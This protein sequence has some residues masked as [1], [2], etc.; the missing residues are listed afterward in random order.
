MENKPSTNEAM[1]QNEANLNKQFDLTV[2]KEENDDECDKSNHR[3]C[4]AIKRLLAALKYYDALNITNNKKNCNIFDDFINNVYD[5]QLLDDFT[6]LTNEHGEEL[7]EISSSII[8]NE[9]FSKCNFKTCQFTSRHQRLGN[10]ENNGNT[11]DAKLTFY[12]ETMDS[13][14]FYLFHCFDAG[15]RT[16][17]HD[18]DEIKGD[19]ENKNNLQYFD[20][21]F[22]RINKMISAR[23]DATDSFNRFKTQNTKF[24][25]I[26]N[27]NKHKTGSYIPFLYKIAVNNNNFKI[28]DD[29]MASTTFLDEVYVHL[30]SVGVDNDHIDTLKSFVNEQEFESES[31]EYDVVNDNVDKKHGNI[32]QFVS[33]KHCFKSIQD[34]IKNSKS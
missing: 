10:H 7:Q 6:H 19:D 2:F 9:M 17:K 15:L 25:I 33:N 14:H 29:S 1:K 11:L 34:F 13:L 20:A 5:Y 3:N 30:E 26:T 24:R 28:P 8:D 4:M 16:I 21:A 23:K 12:K 31:I 27:D 22:S 32:Q 18:D